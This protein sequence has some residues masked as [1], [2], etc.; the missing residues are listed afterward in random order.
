[1]KFFLLITA[2]LKNIE[3]DDVIGNQRVSKRSCT[4]RTA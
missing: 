2:R 1:M 4:E 3:K